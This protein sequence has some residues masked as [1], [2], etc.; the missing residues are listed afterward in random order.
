MRHWCGV[1]PG[2]AVKN[3]LICLCL[4]SLCG[5]APMPD[6]AAEVQSFYKPYLNNDGTKDTPDA[7][8]V[9]SRHATAHLK[10]LIAADRACEI[11]EQGI[12]NIDHDPII[13]GQ[14]FSLKK[15]PVVKLTPQA[16][17]SVKAVATFVSLGDTLKV[18]YDF[19]QENG[20]WLIADVVDEDAPP[21]RMT[22]GLSQPIK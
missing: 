22:A 5:A 12:C 8:D 2:G 20:A 18:E 9:I 4:L 16:D 19:V 3:C 21:W 1:A 10:Q 6:L 11:R 7:M 15:L 14:D 13:D 17:G